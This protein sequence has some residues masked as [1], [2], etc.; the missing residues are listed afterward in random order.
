MFTR[1]SFRYPYIVRLMGTAS[2]LCLASVAGGG[3]V[4]DLIPIYLLVTILML[5]YWM[6]GSKLSTIFLCDNSND[7]GMS[8]WW[9]NSFSY[10][11]VLSMIKF[12]LAAYRLVLKY[13]NKGIIRKSKIYLT[14]G[15]ISSMNWECIADM[16]ISFEFNWWIL[17]C[18]CMCV[19]SFLFFIPFFVFVFNLLF[20]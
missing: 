15:G 7:S 11:V 17:V 4:E 14:I 20:H 16:L 2:M 13:D 1:G 19:L 18:V 5:N 8:W 3:Q 6:I 10:Y 9:Y 12:F